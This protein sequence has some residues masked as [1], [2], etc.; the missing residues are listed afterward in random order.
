M[1]GGFWQA[2]EV[3]QAKMTAY[4]V[5]FTSHAQK[6]INHLPPPIKERIEH[7]LERIS[8]NPF[9]GKALQGEWK[10]AHSHRVGDYR[11]IYK[12]EKNNIL[13]I[14]LKVGHRKNV[15]H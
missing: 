6:D 3:Q 4:K 11:I 15:Y 13:I 10:G 14:V 2:A 8:F 9:L 5:I 7:A 12:I 1:G